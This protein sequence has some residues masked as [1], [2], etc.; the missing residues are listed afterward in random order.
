MQAWA[1][2][3]NISLLEKAAE[4]PPSQGQSLNPP[5]YCLLFN[6]IPMSV[7]PCAQLLKHKATEILLK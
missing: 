7:Q 6:T 5:N 1:K 4:K 3:Y 2:L